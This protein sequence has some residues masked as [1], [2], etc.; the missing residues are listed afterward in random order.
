MLRFTD[1]LLAQ[2]NDSN[3]PPMLRENNDR[4]EKVRI[5]NEYVVQ[6]LFTRSQLALANSYSVRQERSI[7]S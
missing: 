2:R 1:I 3:Y 7:R 5:F 4:R 6:I